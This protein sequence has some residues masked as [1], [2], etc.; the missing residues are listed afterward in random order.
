MEHQ[1]G[2]AVRI[3]V[4]IGALFTVLFPGLAAFAQIPTVIDYSLEILPSG[5][6]YPSGEVGY[7]FLVSADW[8][9][10]THEPFVVQVT[11]PPG[12]EPSGLQCFGYEGQAQFDPATRVLTWSDRLE[13]DVIAFDSCPLHFRIDPTVPPGS[14]FSLTATLTTSKP[15]PKPSNDTATVETVV[16]A[17]AD[18]A[19][20]S[21]ADQR[22]VKPGETIA[23]TL[24]LKNLGPLTAHDVRLT[25]HLSGLVSFVSF[26]Q[27]SGPPA[28]IDAAPNPRDGDC[29][30]NPGC[31]GAIRARYAELPAASVAT[32][33]LVVVANTSFE[34]GDIR[35]RVVVDSSGEIDI[36]DRNNFADEF[37]LAGP[38]ADLAIATEVLES[39]ATH[40]TVLLRISNEGPEAVNAVTVD[41]DL[42]SGVWDYDF[43][44]LVRYATVTPSQGTC[45]AALRGSSVGH[46][47]PPDWWYMNCQVGRLAPGETVTIT[48]AIESAPGIG[49]IAHTASVRPDQNDPHPE[50]NHSQ[51]IVHVP[52]RRSARH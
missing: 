46:P 36:D 21:S 38:D 47:S 50:N 19:V 18:L 35:N 29:F 3:A 31:S 28:A 52:R 34:S 30:P 5:V 26:E 43:A 49:Q 48:V 15:D 39:S 25:D 10:N 24:E 22:R 17:A 42:S 16:V 13:S 23:Y 6:A 4:L 41:T 40:S 45:G 32:F 9:V 37:V 44:D 27:L 8:N 2:T 12:L 20:E 14:I 33:R 1:V 51:V 7:A 11:L